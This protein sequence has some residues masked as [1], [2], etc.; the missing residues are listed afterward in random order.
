MS[1]RDRTRTRRS[2]VGLIAAMLLAGVLLAAAQPA[3]A[4]PGLVLKTEVSAWNDVPSKGALVDCPGDPGDYVVVGA[5]AKVYDG[6][7]HLV[8]LTRVMPNRRKLISNYRYF[9]QVKAE[10]PGLS[11][12]F[13]WYIKAYAVCAR[14]FGLDDYS[15]PSAFI[16]NGAST[17]FDHVEA[18]CPD[19]KVAYA[20]GAEVWGVDGQG[21]EISTGQLGL[22]LNRTSG[23]LDITR[24]TA[25]ESAAGYNGAWRLRSRAICAKRVMFWPGHPYYPQNSGI[26]VDGNLFLSTQGTTY[27]DDGFLVHGIGGGGGT[28]D[29]GAAFLQSLYPTD[30]LHGM[31]VA[32][33]GVPIGG[34]IA[35]HTCAR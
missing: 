16:H 18:V 8:R 11:R 33:T 22:Q 17:T 21:Q 20:A 7:R 26:H 24:A 4:V 15:M 28:T 30:D 6:G 10:A 12:D 2:C 34:M 35:H 19:G 29:G 14:D 3:A 32:M 13:A 23:P 31:T 1:R 5:G 9:V 25:R 27:C